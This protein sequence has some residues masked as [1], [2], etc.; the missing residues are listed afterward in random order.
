M[1]YIYRIEE[2]SAIKRNTFDSGLIRWINLELIV[3]SER[4]QKGK[5]KY[6]Y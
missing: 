2:Y 3:Q 4:S 6:T 1:W 5:D